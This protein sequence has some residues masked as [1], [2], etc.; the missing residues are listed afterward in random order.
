MNTTADIR[1]EPHQLHAAWLPHMQDSKKVFLWVVVS[2]MKYIQYPHMSTR[3]HGNMAL[4]RR[5]PEKAQKIYRD[6]S[7]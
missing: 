3:Y 6:A 7:T 5:T 1:T 4:S 2:S